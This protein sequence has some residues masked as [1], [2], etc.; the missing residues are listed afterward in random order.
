[1]EKEANTFQDSI[2][3]LFLNLICSPCRLFSSL[4]C[5]WYHSLIPNRGRWKF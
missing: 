2:W 1:L 4:M 3:S 5:N